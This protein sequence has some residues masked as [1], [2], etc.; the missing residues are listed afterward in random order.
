MRWLLV[1]VSLVSCSA[2]AAWVDDCGLQPPG[3]VPYVPVEP[4]PWEPVLTPDAPPLVRQERIV[5]RVGG[6]AVPRLGTSGALAGKV[7][8]LSPGHGFTWEAGITAWR[9]QRGN[10]YD[11]VEDLISIETLSQFL[12]PML[13]NAGARVV[14]VRELDLQPNLV[15]LDNGEAGYVEQGDAGDFVDSTLVAWARPTLPM[16]GDATPFAAGTNR[17]MTASATETASA[18]YELTV[19]ADGFYSVSVSYTQY[20]ARVTDAHYEVVHAGG[21][22]HFRVNQQRHGHEWVFL[23]R[24][25]FYAAQPARVVVHN[26]SADPVNR[27]VSLDAVKFGGG[28]GA[29]DRGS[30]ASGRPRFEESARYYTQW[31]GAPSSVWAPSS[32]TPADDRTNDVGTRS[33]FAAWSHDPGEDAVY[34]AWHTNALDGP[35]GAEPTGTNTYVYGNNAPDGTFGTFTGVD[36]GVQLANAIHTEIINDLRKPAGWNTPGWVN[37]GVDTAYFGEINPANNPETPAV[38]LEMAFHDTPADVDRIKEPA[39]RYLAARAIAQ[40]LIKYFATRDGLPV[41]LPAE[42]PTDLSAVNQANGDVVVSWRTPP[43]DTDGV[44][45]DAASAYRVYSSVDGLSWD[46]GVDTVAT[47]LRLPLPADHALYFRVTSLNAGGESMPS[48]V[49]GARR[50]VLGQPFVL[51]VN[52]YGR[53][54]S[55]LGKYETFAP[56][57]AL[58]DVLRLF[59]EKMNDGSYARFSGAAL[60]ANDIGFDSAD[61][62]AVVDLSLAPYSLLTW[63]AG[64]GKPGGAALSVDEQAV[65]TNFRT[66]NLPVFFTGDATADAAFVSSVFSGTTSANTGGLQVTGA[67]PLLGVSTLMLDDGNGGSFDTGT[68]PVLDV[69]GAAISLGSYTAGGNAAIGIAQQT[70]MFGFPFETI[71]GAAQRTDVMHRVIEFLLPQPFDGGL[72]ETDAGVVLDGGFDAGTPPT[73]DAGVEPE[74]AGMQEP[75]AGVVVIQPKPKLSFVGGGCTAAPSVLLSLMM[76]LLL[77]RRTR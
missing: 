1:A 38:L 64:R 72:P 54:D 26:D 17:L 73:P 63:L 71:A 66:R 39:W 44:R 55:S 7:I 24:F 14:P 46:D 25:Y 21:A 15:L 11:V 8:Y 10:N 75:D 59:V 51:L 42:P 41:K 61:N 28:V 20:S 35:G 31:A 12:M 19:P 37:R 3:S 49:V 4:K 9:T 30:G 29:T 77:R 16:T 68:P 70:A 48:A 40:G 62:D 76:F 60:D 5:P 34:V 57:Y 13:I 58:G 18:T 23:G 67:G 47:S 52:G 27:N 32:N 74:D 65:V 53:F 6:T 69:S 45:G 56:T 36:G 33:R 2:L 22:T 43:T 50:P